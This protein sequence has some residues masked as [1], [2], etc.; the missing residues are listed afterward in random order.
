MPTLPPDVR[1]KAIQFLR[2][3]LPA[4]LARLVR[5]HLQHSPDPAKLPGADLTPASVRRE[6][7]AEYGA[8]IPTPMHH[9]EGT[10]VRNLLRRFIPDA[11]LPASTS[12]ASGNWDDY[13]ADVL[14]AACSHPYDWA[15]DGGADDVFIPPEEPIVL[16]DADA[17]SARGL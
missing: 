7:L 9:Q 16:T 3:N 14:A 10:Y 17:Y 8:Y 15:T 11:A 12:D 2:D 6:I 13:Y 1:A 4:D 5:E